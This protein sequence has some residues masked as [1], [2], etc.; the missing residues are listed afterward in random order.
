VLSAE[1]GVETA[2][3]WPRTALRL[4]RG[5]DLNKGKAATEPVRK[6]AASNGGSFELI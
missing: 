2:R 6:D 1:S 4:W 3:T 5:A